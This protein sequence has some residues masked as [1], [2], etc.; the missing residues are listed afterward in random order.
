MDNDI[1][2]L[3]VPLHYQFIVN[4]NQDKL[5]LALKYCILN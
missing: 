2:D 5:I 4:N 3:Q 1:T